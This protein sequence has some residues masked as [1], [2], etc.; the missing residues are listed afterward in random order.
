MRSYLLITDGESDQK[1][2]YVFDKKKN[3]A[4]RLVKDIRLYGVQYFLYNKKKE[5][6]IQMGNISQIECDDEEERYAILFEDQEGYERS[7]EI[8]LKDNYYIMPLT[9]GDLKKIGC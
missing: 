2:R 1:D 7:L 9:K 5:S 8:D 3:Y 6:I 4:G